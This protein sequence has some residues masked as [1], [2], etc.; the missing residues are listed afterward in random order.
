MIDSD[1]HLVAAAAAVY[2]DHPR[3]S[4]VVVGIVGVGFVAAKIVVAVS[5]NHHVGVV[6]RYWM[7]D[8]NGD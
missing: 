3:M 4:A 1:W 8:A 6:L 5:D 7:D 2:D